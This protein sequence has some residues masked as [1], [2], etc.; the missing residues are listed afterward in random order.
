CV[1]ALRFPDSYYKDLAGM[2]DR[3]RK[4]LY[5]SLINAGFKCK[6]P[7]GA[8]YILADF[9]EE[10]GM[11]DMAFAKYLVSEI[12]VACVPGSSFYIS[13]EGKHKLRF[14]FSKKDETLIEAARR[15][16]KLK[17]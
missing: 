1:T 17:I 9:P 12:G 8:Y 7:G 2:Y 10:T 13:K 16:E 14:T 4:I 5:N 3:K 6:M 15:L 11:D